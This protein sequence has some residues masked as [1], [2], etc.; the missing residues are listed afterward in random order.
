M[1]FI[2]LFNTFEIKLK[3][4]EISRYTWSQIRFHIWSFIIVNKIKK[5][6]I[7]VTY[8]FLS[9]YHSQICE[10]HKSKNW[11]IL[12]EVSVGFRRLLI[13]HTYDARCAHY[14]RVITIRCTS[15]QQNHTIRI[16]NTRE[17]AASQSLKKS[18]IAQSCSTTLR[19]C[20]AEFAGRIPPREK[21]IRRIRKRGDSFLSFPCHLIW[22][23]RLYVLHARTHAW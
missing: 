15:V 20:L 9:Q 12:D 22:N 5:G 3:S 17:C 16:A 23:L 7:F 13:S 10:R 11:I 2:V 8:L 1:I 21:L 6:S 18:S 14:A 19:S 4:I